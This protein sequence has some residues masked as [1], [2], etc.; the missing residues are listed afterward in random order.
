MTER[1]TPDQRKVQILECALKLAK[2][3]GGD[4]TSVTINDISKELQISRGLVYS[5]FNDPDGLHDAVVAR[6]I[7]VN[8]NSVVAQA[9]VRKHYLVA[10]FKPAKQRQILSRHLNG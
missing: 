3:Y 1:L 4:Y 8:N 9:V 5:Y 2:N 7:E 10:E 6:A